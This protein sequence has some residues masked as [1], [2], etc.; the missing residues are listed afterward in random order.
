MRKSLRIGSSNSLQAHDI[1][2]F[3]SVFEIEPMGLISA[4]E[5][6]YLV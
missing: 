1:N 6:S 5:Q 4:E 3:R 2:R